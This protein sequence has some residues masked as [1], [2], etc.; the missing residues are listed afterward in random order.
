MVM[1]VNVSCTFL[2]VVG[3]VTI[4][5][6]MTL[7]ETVELSDHLFMIKKDFKKEKRVDFFFIYFLIFS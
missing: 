4:H 5:L 1:Y 3:S 6:I 7:L 2:G